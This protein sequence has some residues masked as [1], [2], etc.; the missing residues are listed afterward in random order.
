MG[1]THITRATLATY[2]GLPD[3]TKE[4]CQR[5]LAI[6]E[7][8]HQ[9]LSCN[10]DLNEQVWF[11][12]WGRTRPDL[13]QAK[14]LVAR[15]LSKDQRELVLTKETRSKV[16]DAFLAHNPLSREDQL[17]VAAKPKVAGLLL[18]HRW[19]DPD[20]RKQVALKVRGSALLEDMAT[21]PDGSY[22]V[23]ELRDLLLTYPSWVL[24]ESKSR[25]TTGRYRF[26]RILFGR[27]PALISEIFDSR[28]RG[29]ELYEE[30]ATSAAGSANLDPISAAK[31]AHIGPDGQCDFDDYALMTMK[32]RLLALLANPRCPHSVAKAVAAAANVN[33]DIAKAGKVRL[34][35]PEI[36][37]A[38]S[39]IE[40]AVVLTW[41]VKRSLPY[42]GEHGYRPSR[43]VELIELACNAHL[44]EE[45][46]ERVLRALRYAEDRRLVE[47]HIVAICAV[48]PAFEVDT[49]KSGEN[50]L[51]ETT[52]PQHVQDAFELVHQ[53][54]GDDPV[55]W[56]TLICLIDDFDGTF[57]ELVEI[58]ENL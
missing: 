2:P 54:L 30:L 28:L 31:L 12:L 27:Y 37:C 16:M 15:N 32:Y 53:R 33:Y 50:S 23:D 26:L 17:K 25:R 3:G 35:K 55:R 6:R 42:S 14:M 44:G 56:E 46:R 47:G 20:I 4:T 19:L 9:H 38:I 45:D 58:A 36:G 40:D 11:T 10:P 5:L 13:E 49:G 18:E 48:N 29:G 22:T 1:Y 34:E 21:A 41:L 7:D 8:M 52:V 24:G 51:A 39:Q 57:G 43:P